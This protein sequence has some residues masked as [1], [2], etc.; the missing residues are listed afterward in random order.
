MD[1]SLLSLRAAL[2]L[3]LAA[4]AGAVAGV[5]T[6]FA[7]EGTAR[8]LLCGLAAAGLAVPF[9]NR[10]VAADSEGQSPSRKGAGRG[11]RRG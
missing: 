10:L 5:L 9:F 6:A 3:L 1:H 8:S 2:V 4:L 11:N 7:G